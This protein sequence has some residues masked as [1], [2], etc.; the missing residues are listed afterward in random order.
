MGKFFRFLID[1]FFRYEYCISLTIFKQLIKICLYTTERK[2]ERGKA[3]DRER[4]REDVF[5]STRKTF[6]VYLNAEQGRNAGLAG[7]LLNL[8]GPLV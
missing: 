6:T 7:P 2:R 5:I 8:S 4:E 1:Y 3:R